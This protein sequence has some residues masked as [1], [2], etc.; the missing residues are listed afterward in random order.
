MSEDTE[1]YM[2]AL[3]DLLEE[4]KIKKAPDKPLLAHYDKGREW[5]VNS[6]FEKRLLD[7]I[8]RHLTPDKL[9]FFGGMS[10]QTQ[11]HLDRLLEMGEGARVKRIWRAQIGFM[12]AEYWLFIT[13]RNKSF[14]YNP[15][16]GTEK[17]QRKSYEGLVARIPGMKKALLDA[18]ADYRTVVVRTKATAAE[19]ARVDADFAAIKA[20]KRQKPEGETDTRPMTDE[21]FWELVD[22]GLRDQS[23]GERLDSLPCRL[24]LFKPAAIRGF[25]KILRRMDNAACRTDIWTLAYL[26]R[27]GCSDDSFRDF[28]GWL[29]MQGKKVFEATLAAPDDF[30]VALYHGT[31]GG[32]DGLQDAAPMAYD[33]REGKPFN[34]AKGPPLDLKGPPIDEKDFAGFLPKI[35]AAVNWTG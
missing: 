2:F 15:S 10:K 35:A 26:L 32:M 20:E 12:K 19:I 4:G 13:E 29:I 11:K 21:L 1:R 27:G 34:P 23:I 22:H 14:A 5:I 9:V 30:N 17:E 28:R 16:F 25:D 31:S 8:E 6:Y 18:M 24:A 7:Q 3:V 33:L